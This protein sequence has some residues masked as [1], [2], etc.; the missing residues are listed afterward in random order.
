MCGWDAVRVDNGLN[1]RFIFV[2]VGRPDV[3]WWISGVRDPSLRIK[4][5]PV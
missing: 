5:Q 4:V 2:W 1:E 3:A